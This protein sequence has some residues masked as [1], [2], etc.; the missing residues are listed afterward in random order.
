[1]PPARG[2]RGKSA[3]VAVLATALTIMTPTAAHASVLDQS[4]P[5]LGAG[6][7]LTCPNVSLVQT[8]TA[9]M[10]GLLDRVEVA[11]WRLGPESLTDLGVQIQSVSP[12]GFPTSFILALE[13][14]AASQLPTQAGPAMVPVPID[15][16]LRVFAGTRYAIVLVAIGLPCTDGYA[17]QFGVDGSIYPGG[18]AFTWED[19]FS[20][21]S[22]P[23]PLDFA[24]QTFVD[25]GVIEEYPFEGFFPPMRNPPAM[26]RWV[27]AKPLPVRFSLG[28]D[29]GLDILAV[30][31]RVARIDCGTQLQMG[32]SW[33]GAM[34]PLVL[35]SDGVYEFF[36]NTRRSV[37]GTCRRLTVILDD[38]TS[39]ELFVRFSPRS[40]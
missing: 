17:W 15:P 25:D 26:N 1:M 31:P 40:S 9:G 6:S 34:S 36:W 3:R 5:I 29:L 23:L 39:H 2:L 8:F 19:N 20:R 32:S 21:I 12:D 30:P 18:D 4:Q 10:D 22:A 13:Q 33:N 11:A 37:G 16:P 7:Y 27:A 24:F 28:G 38:G 35:R 14:V